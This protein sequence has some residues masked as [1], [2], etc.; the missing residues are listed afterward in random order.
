MSTANIEHERKYTIDLPKFYAWAQPYITR[1]RI[2]TRVIRQWYLP[3]TIANNGVVRIR[4]TLRP[5]GEA[6][7]TQLTIKVPTS[8]PA[9]RSEFN[10]NATSEFN[11]KQFVDALG[12]ASNVVVKDRWDI[13]MAL[14]DRH[15]GPGIEII[16]DF[17][18][19]N[20]ITNGILEI[21]NPP[22]N[23]V[24]PDFIARDVTNDMSYTNYAR[25]VDPKRTM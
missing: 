11:T 5:N 20:G 2:R 1:G 23:W 15:P 19:D 18:V 21:E 17:F 6:E 12:I 9:V 25:A 14:Y 16:V 13:T 24:L 4:E 22:A 10:F 8:D 7:L 3:D